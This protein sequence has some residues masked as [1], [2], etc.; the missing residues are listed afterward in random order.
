MNKLQKQLELLRKNRE[1]ARVKI[2]Y[3]KQQKDKA[4][5]KEDSK[6]YAKHDL[7]FRLYTDRLESIRQEIEVVK[8]RIVLKE[9]EERKKTYD[10]EF[11]SFRRA[12]VE[13]FT[14]FLNLLDEEKYQEAFEQL[15]EVESQY[16]EGSKQFLALDL[17]PLTTYFTFVSIKRHMAIIL[18]RV[19]QAHRLKTTRGPAIARGYEGG[20]KEKV[21]IVYGIVESIIQI[22]MP[23]VKRKKKKVKEAKKKEEKVQSPSGTATTKT[24]VTVAESRHK[25]RA[26][27]AEQRAKARF[28]EWKKQQEEKK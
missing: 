1:S 28:L 26:R 9:N 13:D 4:S 2:E 10:K 15:E 16:N 19:G 18:D 17:K 5:K 6:A 27:E 23:S 21:K 24:V 8:A 22:L 14:T 20:T 12:L 7:K 25:T 3:H 11:I